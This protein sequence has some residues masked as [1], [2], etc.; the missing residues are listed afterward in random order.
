VLNVECHLDVAASKFVDWDK[1]SHILDPPPSNPK[2]PSFHFHGLST[3]QYVT[4]ASSAVRGA[5]KEP[6]KRKA[7]T[8]EQF[9]YKSAVWANGVQGPKSPVVSLSQVDK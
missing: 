1:K 3:L 6:A 4:R 2:T 5:L 7:M 8:Q 9:Q